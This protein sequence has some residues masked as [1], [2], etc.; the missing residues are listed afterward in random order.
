METILAHL[1]P[2]VSRRAIFP[3]MSISVGDSIPSATLR[4][5]TAEGPQEVKTDDFF[6]GRKVVLFAVPGAF[7]PTCNNDHLPS[8]RDNADAIR[9]KGV[10]E[11]ACVAI[12]DM[13]ALDAWSKATESAGKI[14][15]LSDGNG[16]LSSAMGMT[17][18]GSGFGLGT[19]SKRYAAIVD[20]GK[21]TAIEVEESPGAC[22]V[23]S[24]SKILENL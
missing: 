20:D 11:I 8:F 9:E 5:L 2:L 6:A 15:M 24:G 3:A 12:N 23:S 18:D 4:T 13:F 14:T 21:V 1:L 22:S 17:F 16:E 7:T 10:A 19:R